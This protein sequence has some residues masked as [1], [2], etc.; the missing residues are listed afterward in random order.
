MGLEKDHEKNAP[1]AGV[2]IGAMLSTQ[3]LAASDE[4]CLQHN[5]LASWRAVDDSTLEMTDNTMKCYAVHLRN[6]CIGVTRADAKLVF[7]TWTNLGCLMPGQIITVTAP[8][9][10][11]VTCSIAD[12]QPASA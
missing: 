6:R 8:G 2:L 12:V 5:R 9:L 1:I 11:P 7:R 10:G 3:V 4:A